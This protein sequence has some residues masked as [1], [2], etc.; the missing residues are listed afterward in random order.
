[1]ENFC[2]KLE[3]I[4]VGY[5]KRYNWFSDTGKKSIQAKQLSLR[6]MNLIISILSVFSSIF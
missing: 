1:M 6:I 3:T 5:K 4:D 2:N